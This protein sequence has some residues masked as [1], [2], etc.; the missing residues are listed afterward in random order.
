[1]GPNITSVK[2]GGFVRGLGSPAAP[3]RFSLPG[4]RSAVASLATVG[5]L[6]GPSACAVKGDAGACYDL[7]NQPQAGGPFI[8]TS[9]FPD[10]S[11]NEVPVG[12]PTRF[13]LPFANECDTTSDNLRVLF[14]FES[15]IKEP[16][17][18]SADGS[19]SRVVSAYAGWYADWSAPIIFDVYDDNR[20]THIVRQFGGTLPT[21]TSD[22]KPSCYVNSIKAPDTVT[23]LPDQAMVEGGNT[24][25]AWGEGFVFTDCNGEAL[26]SVIYTNM[27]QFLTSPEYDLTGTSLVVRGRIKPNADGEMRF[28]LLDKYGNTKIITYYLPPRNK[29]KLQSPDNY[30]EQGKQTSF[31]L[32]EEVPGRDKYV[33]TVQTPSGPVVS[34]QFDSPFVYTPTQYG[35]HQIEYQVDTYNG[36]IISINKP[37]PVSKAGE[38]Y[39]GGIPAALTATCSPKEIVKGSDTLVHCE[40]TGLLDCFGDPA[41]TVDAGL[42]NFYLSQILSNP[43]VNYAGGTL[44]VDGRLLPTVDT[45]LFRVVLK[46]NYDHTGI[47]D[48]YPPSIKALQLTTADSY[49]QLGKPTNFFLMQ[50]P[51]NSFLAKPFHYQVLQPGSVLDPLSVFDQAVSSYDYKPTVTGPHLLE[52][53]FTSYT[54]DLVHASLPFNANEGEGTPSCSNIPAPGLITLNPFVSS[55]IRGDSRLFTITFKDL[56]DCLGNALNNPYA[57][58]VNLLMYNSSLAY[59]SITKT[60]TISGR[61]RSDLFGGSALAASFLDDYGNSRTFEKYIPGVI[62]PQFMIWDPYPQA[63]EDLSVGLLAEPA[64]PLTINYDGTFV[65]PDKTTFNWGPQTSSNYSILSANKDQVG[66]Y[67]GTFTMTGGD[68]VP[69]TIPFSFPVYENPKK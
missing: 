4:I 17:P 54:N 26:E 15:I 36:D 2:T 14:T 42:T 45:G 56:T 7:N 21:V 39:C 30:W 59:D 61:F 32:E 22:A 20:G 58:N 49:I 24:E 37:F 27:G 6:L 55:F 28:Q 66:P 67:A 29:L 23:A 12:H 60:L 8:D 19:Y 52:L 47:Q 1:M 33:I 35:P 11:K 31:Y 57:N 68:G 64:G 9:N 51:T 3:L 13:T 16:L 62:E 25:F 5:A 38:V 50:S 48:F 65:K 69:I 46:D 43:V 34:E 10:P 18:R 53:D 44:T 41:L 40:A 63:F